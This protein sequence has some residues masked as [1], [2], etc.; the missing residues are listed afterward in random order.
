MIN[1]SSSPV[2][3]LLSFFSDEGTFIKNDKIWL[4]TILTFLLLSAYFVALSTP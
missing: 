3:N 1:M 2:Y 4:S